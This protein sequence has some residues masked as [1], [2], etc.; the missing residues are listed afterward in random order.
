MMF[1]SYNRTNW[2]DGD[3]ITQG[4]LNNIEQE[5]LENS[6]NVIKDAIKRI[7]E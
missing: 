7:E 5:K 6:I 3:V 4:R 1:M 2:H